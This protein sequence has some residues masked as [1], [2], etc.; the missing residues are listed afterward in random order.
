MDETTSLSGKVAFV[1][2]AARGIGRAIAIGLA[3]A[4][5]DVAVADAHPGRF[6]GERYYRLKRRVSGP[7]E[8]VP[9]AGAVADLG[10]RSMELEVDVADPDAVA[11]ALERC[12]TELGDVDVLV[13]N[14]GIVNNIA[15]I[16]DMTPEAW[17]HELRVNLTGMFH[18]VR[19]AV[20]PMAARGWGRVINMAS[21]AA[22]TPG[23]GQPA[24]S[25]SKAG[26]VAF[27]RAVAQE[28]GPGGVTANAILP[29]LIGTPLV[30]S[31]PAELRDRYVNVTPVARLGEP[32]DIA[33]LAVFLASPAA[34]FLT[35]TAIPCDGGASSA[36]R[37]GLM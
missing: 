34:G 15:L 28:F 14:A 25:A 35:G 36:A 12:R 2:G 37:N 18:T 9:T 33:A 6:E 3:R 19:V 8:D 13:N 7:D 20:P 17:E 21:V 16:A 26:V 23:L 29:G 4:G 30:R 1:T 31:M 24:Y 27:T 32:E 22:L 11:S 5:A 10:R